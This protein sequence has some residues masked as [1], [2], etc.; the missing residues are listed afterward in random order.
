MQHLLERGED[1]RTIKVLDLCPPQRAEVL[2][3]N[4]D[5]V[6]VDVGDSASVEAAFSSKWPAS[7]STQPLTVFHTVAYIKPSDRKADFLA[8]YMR[9]NV[10]GTRKVLR[11]AKAAKCFV[12]IA[13]SSASI[14]LKPIQFFFAPWY[15][16]PTNWFQLRV[17]ADPESLDAP[18]EN[19]TCCYAYPKA[20]AENLVR[21]ADSPSE[22]FRTGVIRPVSPARGQR[23]TI[24]PPSSTDRAFPSHAVP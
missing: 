6:A 3:A 16:S 11:A 17:N 10:E 23:R 24:G 20:Q 1:P 2:S 22:G 13:T 5:Y 8:L 9:V 21:E 12:F 19:F 18:L 4:L 15:N 14:S 7:A